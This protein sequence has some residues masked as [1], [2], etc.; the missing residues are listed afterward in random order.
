MITESGAFRSGTF[1]LVLSGFW[2]YDL[3]QT[4]WLLKTEENQNIYTRRLQKW[5]SRKYQ[6]TL[7]QNKD[8]FYSSLP[9]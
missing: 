2:A 9:I 8:T 4:L 6:N 7:I 3:T 1:Y 5:I